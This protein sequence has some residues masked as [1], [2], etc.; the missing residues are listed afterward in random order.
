VEEVFPEA[1]MIRV[2]L[3]NLN[4]HTPAALYQTFAL[5]EARRF[6]KWNFM[7]RPNTPVG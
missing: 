4:A 3:D 5:E 2:V 6:R 1:E 7:T